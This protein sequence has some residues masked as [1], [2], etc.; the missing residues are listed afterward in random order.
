[1]KINE[2][3]HSFV[4]ICFCVK[5]SLL[6]K[7]FLTGTLRRDGSSVFGPDN[8]YGWFPSVGVAWQVGKEKFLKK[9]AW[10]DE[11][12]I[13][14]SKGST[15]YNKT[16]DP[17]NQYTLYATSAGR[18][19]YDINGTSTSPAGGFYRS[20]IGN[21]NTGWQQDIVTNIG[22]DGILWNGKLSIAA[23]LYRKQSSGLLFPLPL[24]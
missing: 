15:G 2:T 10:I 9:Y 12:K 7:Y 23:D 5:D 21:L 14:I 3:H 20:R 17:A 16:I 24:M 22:F 8:R 1:M 19:F 6:D 13:R 18:S 4:T 11:L